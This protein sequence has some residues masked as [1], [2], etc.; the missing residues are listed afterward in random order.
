LNHLKKN[1]FK[2][3]PKLSACTFENLHC[4]TTLYECKKLLKKG[5]IFFS[6]GRKEKNIRLEERFVSP[7]IPPCLNKGLFKTV[8]EPFFNELR[9]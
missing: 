7:L 8:I 2:N 9:K 1:P 4:T 5:W 3:K 6:F